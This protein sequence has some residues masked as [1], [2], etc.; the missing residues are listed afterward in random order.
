MTF[1]LPPLL[2]KAKGYEVFI[3]DKLADKT[4]FCREYIDELKQEAKK[5]FPELRE[6]MDN[7]TVVA[8]P[9]QTLFDEV[10][11]TLVKKMGFEAV[12]ELESLTSP[13]A[14]RRRLNPDRS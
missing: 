14:L 8:P 10:L 11:K 12:E 1:E 7:D 9:E 4:S 13:E 3:N 6:Y 2:V 5:E